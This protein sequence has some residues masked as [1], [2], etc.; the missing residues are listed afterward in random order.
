MSSLDTTMLWVVLD[1]DDRV[2]LICGGADAPEVAEDWVARG[3]RV[4]SL[5]E[6]QVH[7]A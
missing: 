6:H 5:D 2:V 4:V 1:G 3:F 7:A